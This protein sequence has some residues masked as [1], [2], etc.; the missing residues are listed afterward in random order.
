MSFPG[1][2]TLPALLGPDEGPK[3]ARTLHFP[4]DGA[5]GLPMRTLWAPVI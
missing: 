4:L 5:M 2:A 3:L 1:G